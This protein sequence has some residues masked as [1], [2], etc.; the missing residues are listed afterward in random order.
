MAF[1]KGVSGN[2]T[3]RPRGAAGL[4]RYVGECTQDGK[5]LIDRLITI[6]RSNGPLREVTAATYALLDRYAGKSMQPSEIALAVEQR[7]GVPHPAN[8]DELRQPD[9]VTWLMTYRRKLLKAAP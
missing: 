1:V 9:K 3:G 8:W 2:P 7:E 5:E 6:S 4:S